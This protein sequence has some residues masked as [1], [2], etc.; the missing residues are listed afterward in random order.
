MPALGYRVLFVSTEAN[1]PNPDSHTVK[2]ALDLIK[3]AGFPGHRY[4]SR[5]DSAEQVVHDQKC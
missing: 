2:M 1:N 5:F 3:W 4:Q